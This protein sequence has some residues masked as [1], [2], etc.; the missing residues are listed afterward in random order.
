MWFYDDSP[1][2]GTR[3]ADL[4]NEPSES[5]GFADYL[6][7]ALFLLLCIAIATAACYVIVPLFNPYWWKLL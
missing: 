6:S 4:D 3:P 5:A 1:Y 2:K 7:D